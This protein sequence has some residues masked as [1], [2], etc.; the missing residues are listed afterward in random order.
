VW[1]DHFRV[2]NAKSAEVEHAAL[3][4]ALTRGSRSGRVAWQFAR[5]WAGRSRLPRRK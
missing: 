1:L 5:D 2:P 4:W 3:N